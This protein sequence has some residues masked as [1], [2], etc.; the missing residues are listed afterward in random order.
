MDWGPGKK[1]AHAL[2]EGDQCVRLCAMH[3]SNTGFKHNPTTKRYHVVT[4]YLPVTLKVTESMLC[5]VPVIAECNTHTHTF[6]STLDYTGRA[7]FY[8][9]YTNV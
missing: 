3:W 9:T 6:K 1:C 8:V 2:G 7:D 4:W 5:G